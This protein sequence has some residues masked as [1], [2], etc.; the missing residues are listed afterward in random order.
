[1]TGAASSGTCLTHIG[2]S[3]R[4]HAGGSTV[5]WV[6]GT[7]GPAGTRN[8]CLRPRMLLADTS[9]RWCNGGQHRSM[10][11]LG[12]APPR[13]VTVEHHQAG[14]QLSRLRVQG[15]RLGTTAS[16][17]RTR[18]QQQQPEAFAGP[19]YAE[20]LPSGWVYNTT[21]RCGGGGNAAPLTRCTNGA[22]LPTRWAPQQG[23][24]G[25]ENGGHRAGWQKRVWGR[26]WVPGPG[27][28]RWT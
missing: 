27:A 7:L 14:R 28:P 2:G 3:R 19:C 10:S 23:R 9:H 21:R 16:G 20:Q 22:L 24:Q 12:W 11:G 17:L 6:P 1:M 8:R 25:G 15:K 4:V 5:K 26:G 18:M 13:R